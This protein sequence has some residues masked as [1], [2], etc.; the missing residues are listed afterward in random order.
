MDAVELMNIGAQ[1]FREHMSVD[2]RIHYDITVAGDV[3]PNVVVVE[4]LAEIKGESPENIAR[5]ALEN[6]KKLFKM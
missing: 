5:I 2:C 6:E 4:K 3:S 1:F